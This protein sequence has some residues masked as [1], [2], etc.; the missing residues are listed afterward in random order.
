MSMS[1]PD[2][3]RAGP[4]RNEHFYYL[5]V[6]EEHGDF[7]ATIRDLNGPDAFYFTSYRSLLAYLTK[8]RIIDY[9]KDLADG[10]ILEYC[11]TMES[12]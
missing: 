8:I 4:P 12:I 3:G 9:E 10:I 7:R 11:P 2:Y 6:W 1:E 5:R